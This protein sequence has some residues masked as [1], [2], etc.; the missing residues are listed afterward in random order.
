[1]QLDIGAVVK[2]SQAI[3]GEIVLDRLVEALMT[4]ALQHAGAERGLLIVVRGDSLQIVAEA[5]TDR[6]KV[7]V[8]LRQESVTSSEVPRALLQTVIRTQQSV[9]LDDATVLNPFSAD[10]YFRQN[11]EPGPSCVCPW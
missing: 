3:S 9:I 1:M 11:R 10:D 8:T 7:E 6:N 5:R 4:I 2:A